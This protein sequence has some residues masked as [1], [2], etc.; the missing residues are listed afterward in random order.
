MLGVSA[1]LHR[2]DWS[3]RAFGWLRRADHAMIFAFIAGTYTPLCVIG[4][5]GAAG[6]KLLVLAWTGAAL[7]IVRALAWPTRHASSRRCSTSRSAGVVL[8]YLPTVHAALDPVAFGA[9]VAG[10]VCY[11]VGAAV[12]ASRWPDPSPT[13]FGFHEVF[14]RADHRWLR[15]SLRRGRARRRGLSDTRAHEMARAGRGC[16]VRR[17]GAGTADAEIAAARRARARVARVSPASRR[18]VERQ[19]HD[20]RVSRSPANAR[21]WSRPRG[22][23]A[24]RRDVDAR[25]EP[26]VSRHASRR[27]ARAAHRGH[28]TARAALRV[29]NAHGRARRCAGRRLHRATAARSSASTRS[30]ARRPAEPP[31]TPMPTIAWCLPHRRASSGWT[32]RAAAT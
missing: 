11:T 22:A 25:L 13:V 8:A 1:T 17:G 24:R 18:P 6:T 4:V 31:P 15:V 27:R 9:V 28:A 7:G 30:C 29:A 3:P 20:V 26:H 10:G 5:G 23:R 12:Y 32:R 21:P 16:R 14:P 19:P 2:A